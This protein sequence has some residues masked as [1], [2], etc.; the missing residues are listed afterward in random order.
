MAHRGNLFQTCRGLNILSPLVLTPTQVLLNVDECMTQLDDPKKD[1][2]RL[3]N[4]HLREC[5]SLAQV[6]EDTA[7]I[8][9]IQKIL[10]AESI[11]CRWRSV[12]EAQSHGPQC[13]IQ[14]V[15]HSMPRGRVKSLRGRQQLKHGTK[16]H[17][18]HPYCKMPGY[19][20][21][22]DS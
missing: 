5:L 4:V 7:S 8:I 9:A 21:I 19:T 3:Q 1:A 20:A 22:L 17:V 15:I 12:Q 10:C 18:G 16:W 11:R 14:Q 2:P 6:R 13:L